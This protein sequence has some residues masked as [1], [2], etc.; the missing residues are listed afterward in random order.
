MKVVAIIQARMGSTRL[1]GKI[2]KTVNGKSLL[3]YQI[4]RLRDCKR[5][6]EIIIATT[7][8]TQDNVIEE[9]CKKID[10]SVFRG[11][12]N[13]VL[14]R[15]FFAAQKSKAQTIVRITSD[16]PLIDPQIVD[17]VVEFYQKNPFDYVSN[18]MERT[19]PRGLDTEV[20]SFE[21]L[22]KV[23]NEAREEEER[24]HVTLHYYRNPDQFSIGS[25]MNEQ[26]LSH[27]RLTVDTEEDFDLI[28]KIINHLYKKNTKFRLADIVELMNINPD[29]FKINSHVEQKKVLGE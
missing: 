25:L 12:E 22:T 9:F 14:S 2:L 19:F 29:W 17:S 3:L 26:N 27:F 6:D 11:S 23:Y 24:E 21:S 8:K 16:C 4:E 13:D 28:Q 18:V 5:V 20:F 15:Y 10:I 7:D 1:P